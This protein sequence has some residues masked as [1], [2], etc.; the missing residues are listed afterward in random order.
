MHLQLVLAGLAALTAAAPLNK[1]SDSEMHQA[2]DTNYTKYAGYLPYYNYGPYSPAVEAE[3]AKMQQEPGATNTKRDTAL[4]VVDTYAQYGVY[5]VTYSP[6]PSE[7]EAEAA[8]EDM[9]KRGYS[10][11]QTYTPYSAA[12]E[13]EAEKASIAKRGYSCY[14][15]YTPYSA[16]VEAEAKKM[17]AN[18][19]KRHMM[20]MPKEMMDN[21]AS[22]S[23]K[24]E[25]PKDVQ[26]ASDS[27]YKSYN[28]YSN[29][30]AYHGAADAEIAKTE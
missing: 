30:G 12:V 11:Y 21:I 20:S 7:V 23:E 1:I 14:E 25:M 28:P 18:M 8:K 19:A 22:S 5:Y 9:V 29:Y 26:A 6:Y 4:P 2:Q 16:A 3:A 17:D 10:C 13:A 15:T 27:W 24:R